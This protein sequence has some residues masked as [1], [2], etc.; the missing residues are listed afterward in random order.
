LSPGSVV[1]NASRLHLD[2][3]GRVVAG[4]E[5]RAGPDRGSS[6]ATQHLLTDGRYTSP[7]GVMTG[8]FVQ[9]LY[10]SESARLAA[11]L[12][13]PGSGRSSLP[14][15]AG[16]GDRAPVGGSGPGRRWAAHRARRARSWP[17]S[18]I[19]RPGSAGP[20][21]DNEI[22]RRASIFFAGE[23][24][25][26]TADRGVRR[27]AEGRGLRGRVDLPGPARAR[28]SGRRKPSGR[29]ASP[30]GRLLSAP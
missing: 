4:G 22:L 23:L 24:D 20:E 29:G 25:S 21:E 9:K 30:R 13:R 1:T 6:G 2:G 7:L 3:N 10:S 8:H 16:Q 14:S 11:L 15:G 17:R 12:P 27:G 28:L 5:P 19:S 26:R 18:R